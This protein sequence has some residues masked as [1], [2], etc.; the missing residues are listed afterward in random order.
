[1]KIQKILISQQPVAGECN[2]YKEIEEKYKVKV[3]FKPFIQI[4]PITPREFRQ[5]H[6]NINDFEGVIFCS[7]NN[8]DHFFKICDELKITVGD[9][10][11]Y[12]CINENIAYYLQK[13]IVYR[14]RKVFFGNNSFESIYDAF[15]KFKDIKYLLPITEPHSSS[16]TDILYEYKLDITKLVISKTVFS[17]LKDI[18]L[19]EYQILI[20]FTSAGVQSLFE[21][22]PEFKQNNMIIGTSGNKTY[23]AATRAGLKVEIKAPTQEFPS[24]LSALDAFMKKYT[25]KK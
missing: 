10:V 11:K 13:Y 21:N 5:Q 1:M 25:K 17:N 24:I 14:K 20:L 6:I 3:E 19:N 15:I 7:K 22:F 4:E 12:F 23:E 18:N 16:V 9:N 8:V 2:R